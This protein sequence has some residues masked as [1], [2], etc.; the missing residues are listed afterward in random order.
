MDISLQIVSLFSSQVSFLFYINVY[1][2]FLTWRSNECSTPVWPDLSK[3]YYYS[4]LFSVEQIFLYYVFLFLRP[5]RKK[6]AAEGD[7]YIYQSVEEDWGWVCL[8]RRRYG[9]TQYPTLL[10]SPQLASSRY[11]VKVS[12]E[13]FSMSEESA[14]I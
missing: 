10:V 4:Y 7:K 3:Y 9:Y 13:I 12:W 2:L 1:F 11:V 14:R 8:R 5:W 6:E